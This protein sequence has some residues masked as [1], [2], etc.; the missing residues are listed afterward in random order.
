MC[1][2]VFVCPVYRGKLA[3][4]FDSGGMAAILGLSIWDKDVIGKD[5]LLVRSYRRSLSARACNSVLPPSPLVTPAT[6]CS[7][8][9]RSPACNSV[10]LL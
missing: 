5:D 8:P 7:L 6:Q 1:V 3:E 4:T 2:W 10:L 9:L